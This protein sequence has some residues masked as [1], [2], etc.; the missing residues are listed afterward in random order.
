MIIQNFAQLASTALRRQAL[1]IVEAGF[2]AINTQQAVKKNFVYNPK[3]QQLKIFSQQ[4]NLAE[5]K[6]IICVGF[7]KAALEAVTAIQVILK[8]KI[9]CGYVLDLSEGSLGNI[10]CRV[11][12]HPLPS[13]VNV[14]ATKELIAMLEVCTEEDLVI[15]VVSGGGS[16]LLCNPHDL[17]CEAEVEI[18]SALTVKGANIV[19]L[20]TVRKHL[21]QVKGGHLAKIIYPATCI[22][23]IFS[24]VPGN[25][26]E[27]VASGPTVKDT[28]TNSDASEI[29]TKYNILEMCQMPSCKLL[30]TPKEDTYF[31][32][33]HNILFVSS[34]Q[35][36][37]A[38]KE[39]AEE[40]AFQVKIYNTQ[41]QG[42]AKFLG[43][44][45]LNSSKKGYCLLGAGEST[46]KVYG[47]GVGG[48]NQEMALSAL[49]QVKNN[50][51]L[52]CVASDGRDNS[53][54]A[55]AIVDGG[56][57]DRANNLGLNF[58]QYLENNDSYH[59]FEKTGDILLTGKTGSNISDFFVLLEK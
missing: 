15:C 59:F 20:N 58:E 50:Q 53:D 43:L 5:Y 36:L 31:K 26:L 51:V 45:I 13:K 18:I 39:K 44:D 10:I 16:A 55:G 7:G 8:E 38:M 22:S 33:V 42:E 40:L 12:T 9:S 24:D 27:A 21:S 46:V 41:F 47:K 52:V 34:E 1:E 29:L 11:G 2:M 48:R 19:E 14:E 35:A 3:T 17:S 49:K 25:S 54:S 23:L 4:F 32:K 57:R 37:R 28:T 56:L 6:R 30:E